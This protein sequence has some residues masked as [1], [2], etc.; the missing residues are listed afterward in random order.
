MLGYVSR[1]QAAIAEI[2]DDDVFLSAASR[3]V[4]AVLDFA[5]LGKT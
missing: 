1:F 3:V 4:Q 5:R 2:D